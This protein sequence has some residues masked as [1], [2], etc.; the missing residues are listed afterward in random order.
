MTTIHTK[1][2]HT[3]R[4]LGSST[5]THSGKGTAGETVHTQTAGKGTAGSKHT[6]QVHSWG[7]E[8]AGKQRTTN[9]H[10]RAQTLTTHSQSNNTDTATDTSDWDHTNTRST[11]D[12]L[13][14]RGKLL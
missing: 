8:T 3:F 13:V 5:N 9:K 7:R 14:K 12:T 6:Q 2:T 10:Y 1:T 11:T 4:K